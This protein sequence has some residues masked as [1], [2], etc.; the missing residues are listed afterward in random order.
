MTGIFASEFSEI[1]QALR[2]NSTLRERMENLIAFDDMPGKVLEG[3]D[4]L[5]RFRRILGEFT[6]GRI[7]FLG[8]ISRIENDLPR[9]SSSHSNSNRVF[10]SGWSDRL[11]RTQIS[12]FYNQA[13]LTLLKEQCETHCEVPHSSDEM[14]NSP[15]TLHLAGGTHSVDLLLSRLVSCYSGG[16]FSQD[17]KIPN[18]PHCTHVVRPLGAVGL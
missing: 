9:D 16:V 3:N 2:A 18:H 15:C 7:D 10:A 12:R 11:A 5:H 8:V 4:R 13:I 6:I 1:S 14:G 17:L